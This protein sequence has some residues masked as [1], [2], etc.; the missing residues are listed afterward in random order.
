MKFKHIFAAHVSCAAAPATRCALRCP[1]SP[2]ASTNAS[3]E[4]VWRLLRKPFPLPPSAFGHHVCEWEV[5]DG[6]TRAGCRLC[7]KIHDCSLDKCVTIETEDAHVCVIT[8]VCVG[9]VYDNTEFCDT[10]MAKD[11]PNLVSNDNIHAW[12]SLVCVHVEELLDSDAAREAYRNFQS[13]MRQRLF[14]ELS[15]R[16]QS[17]PAAD[18]FDTVAKVVVS[19]GTARRTSF[20]YDIDSR[21]CLIHTCTQHVCEVLRNTHARLRLS[22]KSGD[23]RN[24][25]F[26]LVYLLKSGIYVGCVAIIPRVPEL[27]QFLPHEGQLARYFDFRAKYITD[28]ENKCK[29]A[30]RAGQKQKHL[31]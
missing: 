24:T 2:R 12:E 23:L 10:H 27:E 11:N 6:T 31:S 17:A 29:F 16:L 13:K 19:V 26:G 3:A 22:M 25:I 5:F 21:R 15:D 4:R 30:F 28:V 18:V 7:S 9:R 8:G 14:R 20:Q 1:R